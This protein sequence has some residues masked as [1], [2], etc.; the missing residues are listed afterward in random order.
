MLNSHDPEPDADVI[1]GVKLSCTLIQVKCERDSWGLRTAPFVCDNQNGVATLN[2]TVIITLC[3]YGNLSGVD[4]L[5][6]IMILTYC[7]RDVCG[8]LNST[9]LSRILVTTKRVSLTH[10]E[11][12]R[13]TQIRVLT[14]PNACEL[15]TIQ[16]LVELVDKAP[17]APPSGCVSM[18]TVHPNL[19][20][21]NRHNEGPKS[22]GNICISCTFMIVFGVMCPVLSYVNFICLQNN[23]DWAYHE[24]ITATTA[25]HYC[26]RFLIDQS[27]LSENIQ[28]RGTERR[29][30]CNNPH[31]RIVGT[32]N[33]LS[34]EAYVYKANNLTCS[35]HPSHRYGWHSCSI[36]ECNMRHFIYCKCYELHNTYLVNT[37]II[38][39][40]VKHIS[41]HPF[42]P[43]HFGFSRAQTRLF[44]ETNRS[45]NHTVGQF[46]AVNETFRFTMV[47]KIRKI[48]LIY[49]RCYATVPDQQWGYAHYNDYYRF[50]HPT[51]PFYCKHNGLKHSVTKAIVIRMLKMDGKTPPKTV[52]G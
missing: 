19:K 52:H 8:C 17:Y 38:S 35:K 6:C 21:C 26:Q 23:D 51:P 28:I 13:E 49:E 12:K 45:D 11:L 37:K 42:R 48:P 4:A 43:R 20:H 40:E 18:C 9:Y 7:K 32:M 44:T 1:I 22:L 25:F 50:E 29:G 16:P 39:A 14:R 5:Y 47:R 41:T 15:Q 31:V 27:T 24:M 10:A 36:W 46:V 33:N 30:M 3:K 34:C 2:Y